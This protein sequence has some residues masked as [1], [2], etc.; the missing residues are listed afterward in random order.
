MIKII[1]FIPLTSWEKPIENKAQF[2]ELKVYPNPLKS[3][4]L[5]LELDS[6]KIQEVMITNIAGKQV[7]AKKFLFPEN[8]QIIQLENIRNGIYLVKVKSTGGQTR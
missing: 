5:T 8:K 7:V 4:S 1:R 2:K 6:H 3:T